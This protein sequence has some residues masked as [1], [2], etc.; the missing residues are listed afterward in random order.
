MKE[1]ILTTLNSVFFI[2]QLALT[3]KGSIG[4]LV[5][6]VRDPK[7]V[8]INDALTIRNILLLLFNAGK[9]IDLTRPYNI[10]NWFVIYDSKLY[11]P[12]PN[13]YLQVQPKEASREFTEKPKDDFQIDVDFLNYKLIDT[14]IKK[15]QAEA[16]K[17]LAESPLLSQKEQKKKIDEMTN[18]A[19]EG[20]KTKDDGVD[21][22]RYAVEPVVG[23]DLGKQE[24]LTPKKLENV[25]VEF[26][27]DRFNPNNRELATKYG[28]SVSTIRR[29][30]QKLVQ[31][32]AEGVLDEFSK[33]V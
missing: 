29:W 4:H 6:E 28:K 15:R 1:E 24:E 31:M 21:A 22:I 14:P 27:K 16:A 26:L 11:E 7:P 19:I 2:N 33:Q 20:N 8:S 17:M 9:L 32:E 3:K 5:I 25:P 12:V 13:T 18:Y 30:R 10:A 23:I